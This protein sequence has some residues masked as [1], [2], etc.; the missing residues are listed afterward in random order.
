MKGTTT[1]YNNGRHTVCKLLWL[2]HRNT[3]TLAVLAL[4]YALIHLQ[5]PQSYYDCGFSVTTRRQVYCALFLFFWMPFMYICSNID[6]SF[7]LSTHLHI[8]AM[9]VSF[10]RQFNF[11]FLLNTTY[12]SRLT[13][14]VNIIRSNLR[15]THWPFTCHASGSTTCNATYDC[16]PLYAPPNEWTHCIIT[17][18]RSS[19]DD[20]SSR[21][22]TFSTD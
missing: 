4:H 14:N 5:I 19:R 2:I 11:S 9:I 16:V 13:S 17:S 1:R 18:T 15:Q 12:V 6:R 20:M 8:R 3:F 21:R 22:R 7:R 10:L